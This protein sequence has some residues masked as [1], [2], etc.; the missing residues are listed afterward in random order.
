MRDLNEIYILHKDSYT[1]KL[2]EW[3]PVSEQEDTKF[4]YTYFADLHVT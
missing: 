1:Q 3:F 2:T 4:I